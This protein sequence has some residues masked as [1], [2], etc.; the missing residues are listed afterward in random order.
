MT[1][2]API[3]S[4]TEDA[5]RAETTAWARFSAAKDSAEFCA[6]WLAILCMQID[7][8]GAGLLLLGP[9]GDGAYVPAAVWPHVGLDMKYLSPAA[10]RALNERR[11]VVITPDGASTLNRDPRVFVSYPIEVSGVLHGVVVL[12][13][14]QGPDLALQR[15]LRLLLW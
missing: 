14:A 15:T 10:E 12:D 11:G 1:G 6:S 13:V 4:F 5:T 3:Y 9:D 2:A 8:A 7:R